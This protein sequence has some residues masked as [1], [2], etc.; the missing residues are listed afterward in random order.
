MIRAISPRTSPLSSTP[1]PEDLAERSK[2]QA[3]Q[4]YYM[5]VRLGGRPTGE[6][7]SPTKLNDSNFTDSTLSILDHWNEEYGRTQTELDRWKRFREYQISTRRTHCSFQDYQ[8]AISSYLYRTD[9]DIPILNRNLQLQSE[10]DQWIEY[11][12]YEHMR[13]LAYEQRIRHLGAV[14]VN[15]IGRAP[16]TNRLRQ[17][18]LEQNKVVE[19]A[20][21]Q[22]EMPCDAAAGIH[23]FPLTGDRASGPPLCGDCSH[24]RSPRYSFRRSDR[25]R[26]RISSDSKHCRLVSNPEQLLH[27][28]R[29]HRYLKR[30]EQSTWTGSLFAFHE[31]HRSGQSAQRAI[32]RSNR[33]ASILR[34]SARLAQLADDRK[35]PYAR[36]LCHY[37]PRNG[38]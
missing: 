31:H 19:W 10:R 4:N 33:P 7:S 2:T 16:A 25:E 11:Y 1:D 13:A 22:I 6:V 27:S 28:R 18:L 17:D 12:I 29:H 21:E 37:W 8:V 30:F 14:Y 5:L 23:T 15:D 24:L 38:S 32:G 9:G 36:R 26:T 34:R 20:Q 35:H 3:Y